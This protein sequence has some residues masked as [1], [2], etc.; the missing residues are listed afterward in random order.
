MARLSGAPMDTVNPN[1]LAFIIITAIPLLYFIGQRATVMVRIL[2]WCLIGALIYALILT[3]SRSGFLVF[4]LLVGLWIWRSRYK[5]AAIVAIIISAAAIVPS[6]TD[7]QKERYL[8]IFRSDVASAESAQGRIDA[9][10]QD[11]DVALRRPLFGHGLGTSAEANAHFRG[12]GQVSHNLYTEVAQEL[13]FVG[14]AIF[15]SILVAV[16][17]AAVSAVRAAGAAQ[18]RATLDDSVRVAADSILTLLIVN[19][20]FSFASYGLSDPNW[21]MLSGLA[22]A[23]ARLATRSAGG[24]VPSPERSATKRAYPLGRY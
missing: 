12:Y 14:L 10:F 23:T 9:V 16:G 19:V 20:V 2:C 6:M 5:L 22:V 7:L 17:R 15:L 18:S 8:S 24:S 11:F 4:A 3:G 13:G 21:Y 1:G